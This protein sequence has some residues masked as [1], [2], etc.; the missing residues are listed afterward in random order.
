M[1]HRENVKIIAFVGLTGS[2]KSAAVEYLTDKGYPKVYFGGVIYSAMEKAGIPIGEE[3]EK[4]FRVE[5]REREGEDFIVREI[6]KQINELIDAGQKRIIADGIYSW[7]EYKAMK[8]E[9]HS[10]LDV[11]AI[12]TPK[13]L[14]YHRLLTRS[15]RPQTEAISIER[16]H[17][18][19]ETID[20]GGPI[21]MADYF[22]INDGD[23]EKLHRNIDA[24]VS[25]IDF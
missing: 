14:R 4:T 22:V 20:K 9:F 1:T 7:D 2:G 19:I 6:I 15:E 21:A 17:T 24:I 3:N 8:Q 13:H 10:E 18:E 5:I 11:V 25:E 23:K 16:D 12:I